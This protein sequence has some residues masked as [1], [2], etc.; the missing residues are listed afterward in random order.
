MRSYFIILVILFDAVERE[1]QDSSLVGGRDRG[2]M[3][4]DEEGL[5]KTRRTGRG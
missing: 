4:G 1:G 5:G 3:F 2:D